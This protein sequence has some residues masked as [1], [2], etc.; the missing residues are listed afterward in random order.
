MTRAAE[1]NAL[2][3][4]LGNTLGAKGH[5]LGQ[6]GLECTGRSMTA[7]VPA[8]QPLASAPCKP[9]PTPPFLLNGMGTPVHQGFVSYGNNA[10]PNAS[11]SGRQES[12]GRRG[13]QP[14]EK[15]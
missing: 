8:R 11:T 6:L 15:V 14:F 13:D 10:N 12:A 9:E 5:S 1:F 4:I 7:L 2:P 3:V